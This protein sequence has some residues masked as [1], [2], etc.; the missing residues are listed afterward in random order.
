MDKK[1]SLFAMTTYPAIAVESN[2]NLK[3]YNVNSITGVR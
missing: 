2:I 1:S 3:L